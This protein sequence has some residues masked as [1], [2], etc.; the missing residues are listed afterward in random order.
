MKKIFVLC[1]LLA[2]AFTLAAPPAAAAKK[3]VKKTKKKVYYR[4]SWPKGSRPVF[5]VDNG[6]QP[7][8]GI[9]TAPK[10][11]VPKEKPQ[12]QPAKRSFIPKIGYSGGAF[13]VGLD[14]MFN[15]VSDDTDFLLGGGYGSGSTYSVLAL[16]ASLSY[17]FATNYFVG[18]GIDGANYSERVQSVPGLSGWVEKGNRA[19]MELF[20]GA[21]FDRWRL[22]AGFSTALGV[23][24]AAGFCF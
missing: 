19:G 22:L 10:P 1:L 12:S 7:A 23:N 8:T 5:P 16:N 15:Q 24:A 17:R 21:Q 20:A 14:Y 6:T 4:R 9:A 11:A 18:F 3:K 13:L 2:F